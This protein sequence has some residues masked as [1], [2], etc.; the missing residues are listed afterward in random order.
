MER[1]VD[2]VLKP[3]LRYTTYVI[4]V[5]MSDQTSRKRNL[6]LIAGILA[7][8]MIAATIVGGQALTAAA[9]QSANSEKDKVPTVSTSGS[10]TEKVDPDK[11]SV[12]VGVETE[13]KTAAEATRANA[14]LM[15]QVLATLRNAGVKNDQIV[16]G[17]F[18]VYPVYQTI[19]PPCIEI[20]PQPPECYPRSEISGYKAVNSITITVDASAD[21]GKLIDAAVNAGANNVSG[22]YFF[23]SEERQNEIR[24]SLIEKAIENA[25]GRAEKAAAALDMEITGVESV[26]LNDVYFP[27]F[28][29]DVFSAAEGSAGTQILPGQQSVSMNV[30]IV[31]TMG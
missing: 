28:Y 13:G 12:T 27:I 5:V 7:I 14:T 30:S 8:G 2:Y 26:N 20:Y 31:F 11:V 16:T 18:S 6:V 19:S 24:E 21:V 25:K 15:E 1:Q 9:Q 29:K 22:A 23:V 3:R 17:Y 4:Q 10:A